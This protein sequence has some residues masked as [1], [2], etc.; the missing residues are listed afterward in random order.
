MSGQNFKRR[1]YLVDRTYQLRF[2]TRLFLLLLS[3]AAI[4]SL[5]SSGLLWK[6][7][8]SSD[9]NP[10]LLTSAL[11]AVSV[12]ILIELL[13]AVPIVIFFGIRYT[14]RVVGPMKRLKQMLDAI[15]NGDFSQRIT[16]REND[17]LKDLAAAINQMAEKLQQRTPR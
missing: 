17:V 4:T 5:A 3:I 8:Y 10:A 16:L 6:N 11:I 14:H 1:Q 7:M 13:I 9:S 12:T 2:V 15:G